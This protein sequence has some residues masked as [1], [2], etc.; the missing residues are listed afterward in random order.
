VKPT[1]TTRTTTRETT[2]PKQHRF[3]DF[4]PETCSLISSKCEFLCFLNSGNIARLCKDP[5][6]G[7]LPFCKQFHMLFDLCQLQ[8]CT[9]KNCYDGN[10][11]ISFRRW[12]HGE[13]LGQWNSIVAKIRSLTL[14][15][16][17]D[18]IS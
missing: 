9:V 10:P 1:T 17:S 14:S 13:L 18:K 11:I 2:E 16:E 5:V 3:P 6:N 12:L 15:T 8:D 7:N 4:R